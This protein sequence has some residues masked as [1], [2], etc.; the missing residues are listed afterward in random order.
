MFLKLGSRAL[1]SRA[2]CAAGDQRLDRVAGR[3]EDVV[4]GGP[5]GELRQQ[6]LVVGV[7]VLHEPAV[8]IRLEALDG[9]F[10]DVV[11]PVVQVQFVRT[12][13]RRLLLG[14]GLFGDFGTLRSAGGQR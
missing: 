5:G 11:V 12:L 1:S 4:A 6:F 7:V 14:D 9:F 2:Q 8:A 3:H 13:L 10:G